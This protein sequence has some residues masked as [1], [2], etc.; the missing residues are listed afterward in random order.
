[1]NRNWFFWLIESYNDLGIDQKM[2][3]L[4]L[5]LPVDFFS[6]SLAFFSIWSAP[7]SICISL[8]EV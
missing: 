1:M 7:E 3:F 4:V 8:D 6:R 2:T 5:I